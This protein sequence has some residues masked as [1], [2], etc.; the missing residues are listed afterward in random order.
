M[1]LVLLHTSLGHGPERVEPDVQG[2]P[3]RI[4]RLDERRSEVQ[5][6]RGSRSRAAGL[7]V[8][9]LVARAVGKRLADVGR[10]RRLAGRLPLQLNDPAATSERLHQENWAELLT[11]S[12]A[13]RRPRERLPPPVF[14]ALDE[15]HLDRRAR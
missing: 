9:R 14:E 4:E 3:S 5:T 13:T 15:K 8:H 12:Q 6:G 11:C 1:N 2:H 10:E 7:A